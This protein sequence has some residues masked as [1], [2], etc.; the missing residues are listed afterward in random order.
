MRGNTAQGLVAE[1]PRRDPREGWW[2]APQSAGRGGGAGRGS[3]TVASMAGEMQPEDAKPS[4]TEQRTQHEKEGQQG[5]TGAAATAPPGGA[6][7]WHAA[8]EAAEPL[9]AD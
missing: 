6:A 3:R 2:E 4:K 8:H 9:W 1:L 7:S 5:Q